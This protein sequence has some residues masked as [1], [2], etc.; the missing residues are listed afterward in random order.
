MELF[1]L[2]EDH[3]VEVH[4]LIGTFWTC[5]FALQSRYLI[6]YVLILF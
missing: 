5:L 3:L 6:L 4:I 2:L 1:D